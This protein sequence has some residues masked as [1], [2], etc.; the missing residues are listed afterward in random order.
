MHPSGFNQVIVTISF[1]FAFDNVARCLDIV[2][3]KENISVFIIFFFIAFL[4][5]LIGWPSSFPFS[6]LFFWSTFIT[7]GKRSLFFW[8]DPSVLSSN[9]KVGNFHP[10]QGYGQNVEVWLKRPTDGG[11]WRMSIYLFSK[12]FKNMGMP[13]IISMT[14]IW[15]WWLEIYAKLIMHTSMW[16]LLHKALRPYKH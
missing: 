15:Q 10:G 8:E 11:T 1:L 7:Q 12:R 14:C 9:G 4:Q 13:Q 16:T 6:F 2:W 5:S 3:F